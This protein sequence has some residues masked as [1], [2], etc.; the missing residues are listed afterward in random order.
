MALTLVACAEP[1]ARRAAPPPPS[2]AQAAPAPALLART[3]PLP[4]PVDERWA[5]AVR[6]GDYRE[7]SRRLAALPAAR[8]ASP[9][10]RFVRARVAIELEDYEGARTLLERLDQE[11]PLLAKEIARARAEVALARGPFEDAARY[12]TLRGDPASLVKAS[13][14]LERAGKLGEAKTA[15]DHAVRLLGADDDAS[16]V[17][18]RVRARAARARIAGLLHDTATEQTELRWLA[19]EAP[20]TEAGAP[21]V[22][23]LAALVPPSHLTATQQLL[24]AK[25]LAEASRV[26]DALSAIDAAAAASDRPTAA[27]LTRARASAYYVSRSDYG[28]AS[29]LFAQAARLDPKEAP[30]DS[31]LSARALARGGDDARAIERY[32]ALARRYPATPFAEEASYQAA[33]L[34]FLLGQWDASVHA[35]RAY[36]DA[37]PKRRPGRFV[38]SSRYELSLALLAGGHGREAAAT[39]ETLLA[40][41]DDALGRA[42]LRELLGAALADAGDRERAATE[43][44]AV[45]RER[46]L[47][48][49]ALVGA[50]RLVQLGEAPPP[51]FEPDVQARASAPL[52]VALPERAALLARLGYTAEAAQ[53]LAGREQ[54]LVARYAPRGYEALC[55]AYG[56]VGAA[57]E[58]YRVG[59]SAVRGDALD[60]APTDATR[61][62]WDCV[63]PTP[64]SELVRAAESERALPYGLLHA[65]MRQE[66]A[67]RPDAVSSA[68]A[69]GLLQLVPW[70]AEK[71]AVELGQPIQPSLLS[72][73][74]YNV[75]LG[76][77]Y[78][79]KVLTTFGGHVAL[80]AAAYNAGPRAVSRWLEAA[81]NLPLDVWVARIPFAE[82]R[83]Y[84]TRVVGNLARYAYLHGG[85]DAVPRLSL[86]LPKGM[87]AGPEDY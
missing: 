37:H 75:E 33:R 18:L 81:E 35:Y 78:V 80:A 1:A 56:E 87:R 71:V 4:A 86:T 36:L 50:A 44:R 47:S 39:L 51:L 42:E 24:R 21:A 74:S 12:Y 3:D 10:V 65:I 62:A 5:E 72:T 59:R 6:A 7:A 13:L 41:E 34:Q 60:R 9:E 53:E 31:F 48:F 17:A 79:H 69:V 38:A 16:S 52:D 73:P 82:T 58:R 63:Y 15:L 76:A 64:F 25:R 19:V 11:L 28:R 43:L 14:A 68:R 77:Y 32:E 2:A 67:F 84:V 66:S 57:A 70:T 46:P 27:A 8:A 45:I 83:G 49:P 23:A 26:A 40:A 55:E 29:E 61:W 54:E 30:R 85:E 20:E 22:M